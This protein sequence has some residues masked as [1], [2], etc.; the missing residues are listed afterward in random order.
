MSTVNNMTR[1][2]PPMP[3]FELSHDEQVYLASL[4]VQDAYN[5]VSQRQSKMLRCYHSLRALQNSLIPANRLPNEL[6]VMIFRFV[7]TGQYEPEWTRYIYMRWFKLMGVCRHWRAIAL[8]TPY[9]WAKIDITKSMDFTR[10]C[11]ERSQNAMLE[12]FM[13]E[14]I[15]PERD[16]DLFLALPGMSEV[17][18][19][20]ST[21]IRYL[22]L[23][24]LTLADGVHLFPWPIA[25]MSGLEILELKPHSLEQGPLMLPS[26]LAFPKL[27]SLSLSQRLFHPNHPVLNNL[28]EL[29]LDHSLEGFATSM[30]SLLGIL[31][32][33]PELVQ[34]S[35]RSCG[36][37]L[38][39]ETTAYPEPARL[40]FLS[41][42]RSLTLWSTPTSI[43]YFLAHLELPITTN[44]ELRSVDANVDFDDE[45][46]AIFTSLLPR[47]HSKI[48]RLAT[49]QFVQLSLTDE[50]LELRIYQYPGT[51]LKGTLL[52]IAYDEAQDRST[53]VLL[54]RALREVTQLFKSSPVI[55]MTL[56][57]HRDAL[58]V[59]DWVD[60]LEC[61]PRLKYLDFNTGLTASIGEVRAL[62]IALGRACDDASGGV[63]CPDLESIEIANPPMANGVAELLIDCLEF[64]AEKGTRLAELALFCEIVY[65]DIALQGKHQEKLKA[66]VD[67][68][69]YNP[70]YDSLPGR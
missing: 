19:R 54:R 22:R 5:W 50:M 16:H 37:H 51:G 35:L 45:N 10:M 36:P 70:P 25:L 23:P 53:E 29:E 33:C 40:V 17:L 39:D 31:E 60:A 6:L 41:K 4:P 68:F 8:A 52:E 62:F 65:E 20:H 46:L 56:M 64:R 63:P 1:S 3:E 14:C 30:D 11:L 42:L 34:L 12:I 58:T 44:V 7:E 18:A 21:R 26:N 28:V 43:P 66:L 47:D 55:Q 48:L 2:P 13:A 69:F 24:H 27:H 57:G 32:R 9:L 15:P 49:V 67:E 61:M 59:G 38:P